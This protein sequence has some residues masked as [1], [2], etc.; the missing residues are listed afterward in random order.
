VS[1]RSGGGNPWLPF[2]TAPDAVIRLLCLP[3]AGAGAG[4][5]RAWG[6]GFPQGIAACPVQP[7][8]REKRHR[9]PPLTSVHE[10]ASL[11]AVEVIACITPPYALF[12][13]STGALV[14]FQLARRIRELGGPPAVHLFVSG[15]PAPQIALKR[16]ALD[17]LPIADLAAVLRGLGGTPEAVLRDEGMLRRIRRLLVADFAVNEEY[18][19]QPDTPLAIPVTVFAATQDPGTSGAQAAAWAEQTSAAFRLRPIEGNHFA[20]FERAAEVQQAIANAL[21]ALS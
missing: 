17:G 1:D 7:P 19:Y 20:V 14:A 3:H 21:G 9:E 4:V 18:V 6:T 5:Y 15:R 12:G 16:T 8:G 2:G 10:L 13:H 11:L